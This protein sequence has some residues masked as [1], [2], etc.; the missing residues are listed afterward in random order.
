MCVRAYA[1][2]VGYISHTRYINLLLQIYAQYEHVPFLRKRIFFLPLV[3]RCDI[4]NINCF[5]QTQLP[6]TKFK[7][8]LRVTPGFILNRQKLKLRLNKQVLRAHTALVPS[9]TD[10]RHVIL[11]IKSVSPDTQNLLNTCR[12]SYTLCKRP[13]TC[14]KHVSPLHAFRS[15][16]TPRHL[17]LPHVAHL[18]IGMSTVPVPTA[19]EAQTSINSRTDLSKTGIWKKS[20]RWLNRNEVKSEQ[21]RQRLAT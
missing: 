10:T 6:C 21:W 14:L 15:Y 18:N 5:S 12:F 7:A 8:A 17:P 2:Y 1:V 9:L 19:T 13:K 4:Q 16:N 3:S 11:E 20:T